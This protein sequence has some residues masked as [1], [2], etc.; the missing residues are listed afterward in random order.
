MSIHRIRAGRRALAILMAFSAST[1]LADPLYDIRRV[2][3]IDQEHTRDNGQRFSSLQGVGANGWVM[4]HATRYNGQ[5]SS[6]GLSAWLYDGV[7]T[8]EVG[9]GGREHVN[10]SDRRTNQIQSAMNS[11][12]Y[13]HGS[14]ARFNFFG[15]DGGTSTWVWNGSHT[16]RT[17]LF[18][19]EHTSSDGT[20]VSQSRR[21][22]QMGMVAGESLRYSGNADHGRS[23]WLFNGTDNLN[24]GFTDVEHTRNDGYRIS[25]V[26]GLGASA[27]VLGLSVRYNGGADAGTTTW[28]FSGGQTTRIGLYDADHTRTTDGSQVSSFITPSLAHNA[29]TNDAGQAIGTSVRY[30]PAG[31]NNG[32]STWLYDGT[33]TLRLGFTTGLFTTLGGLQISDARTINASGQVAGHSHYVSAW[34]GNVA[35]LYAGGTT[36]QIGFSDLEHTGQTVSGGKQVSRVHKLTNSGYVSGFSERYGGFQN[37]DYVGQSAWV[38]DGSQTLR[39]GLT[40]SEHTSSHAQPMLA[41]RFSVVEFLSESGKAAG[42]SERYVGYASQRGWSTWVWNGVTTIRAGIYDAEHTRSD[43]TVVNGILQLTESGKARGKT[44]RFNGNLLSE[45]FTAWTFDGTDTVEI[46]LYTPV[47][48]SSTGYQ[49]SQSQHMNEAGQVIGNAARFSGTTS[50]GQDAWV[51]DPTLGQTLSLNLS[52]RDDGY[53]FSQ[54]EYLSESGLVLG[55][56]NLYDGAA[57]VGE[58]AFRWDSTNGLSDLGLLI[59]GGLSQAGWASLLR[60]IETTPLDHIV[61]T[62]L[63]TGM[64]G[65][66]GY[67]LVPSGGPAPAMPSQ[68]TW[69][70]ISGLYSD[71]LRWTDGVP[72]ADAIAVIQQFDST[73]LTFSEPAVAQRLHAVRGDVTLAL[74]GHSYSLTAATGPA[75]VVGA[76]LYF[77]RLHIQNGHLSGGSMDVGVDTDRGADLYIAGDAVLDLTGDLVIGRIAD[78]STSSLRLYPGS[79]VN[80][81]HVTINARG[82]LLGVG[83]INADVTNNGYAQPGFSPGTIEIHGDYVQN[84]NGYLWLEVYGPEDFGQLVIHGNAVF[85][86]TIAIWFSAD[87]VFTPGDTLPLILVGGLVDTSQLTLELY[88]LDPSYTELAAR[89]QDGS[90][91]Q[92]FAVPEPATGALTLLGSLLLLRRRKAVSRWWTLIPG[93]LGRVYAQR[94]VGR[95]RPPQ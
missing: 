53:A 69:A 19:A 95:P 18:D 1:A 87:Y 52:T 94:T 33:Q 78:A 21:M 6:L 17:G 14:T 92:S 82:A 86:G 47:H 48:T 50:L 26:Y 76:D 28:S 72:S 3:L 65:Q 85:G 74:G 30:T 89:F 56:Y 31:A 67:V 91:I 75:I 11:A 9:L 80:A 38:Y 77:A 13:F 43:D 63:P 32:T 34:T 42:Q 55:Y 35:W 73:T 64:T 16:V 20:R 62:G 49:N 81:D 37:G 15:A 93:P 68:T 5:S 54:A 84:E 40:D 39:V 66:M 29:S 59:D 4:G 58:R 22:N 27:Q 83:T 51:Y 41:R 88:D 45:G 2:G 60:A 44:E 70:G 24:A 25:T 12:G 10:F 90:W 71:P 61:G 7:I 57:L 79:V 23:V 8:R 46:G 36:F